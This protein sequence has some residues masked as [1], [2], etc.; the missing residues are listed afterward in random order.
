MLPLNFH[1]KFTFNMFKIHL[2][3]FSKISFTIPLDFAIIKNPSKMY[4]KRMFLI[5][6]DK[7]KWGKTYFFFFY[8][9]IFKELVVWRYIIAMHP[10]LI[11]NMSIFQN[12][13]PCAY[14]LF[15]YEHIKVSMYQS[16]SWNEFAGFTQSSIYQIQDV[17]Y[18]V[19]SLNFSLD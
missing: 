2:E 19:I 17:K 4:I 15:L 10:Q 9:M 1:S 13:E 3:N 8:V 5:V 7:K 11:S 6:Y 18:S 14:L 16:D 12:H